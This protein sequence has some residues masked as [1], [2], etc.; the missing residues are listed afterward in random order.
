MRS[1]A[2]ASLPDAARPGSKEAGQSSPRAA[3]E[4][5]RI[6]HHVEVVVVGERLV[7]G[8]G[9]RDEVRLHNGEP[10]S[11]RRLTL[12]CSA[13]TVDAVGVQERPVRA[14]RQCRPELSISFTG[15]NGR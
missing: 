13:L 9:Y 1:T 6:V 3:D 7:Y 5:V 4:Q 8:I 10:H 2:P 15:H 12:A 11:T 14:W